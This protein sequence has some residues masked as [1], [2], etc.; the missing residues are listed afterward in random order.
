MKEETAS[1]IASMMET[2][3]QSGTA[4]SGA[5]ESV[6]AAAKTGTAQTGVM[7]DGEEEVICWYTGFFPAQSPRYVVTVMQEGV[8]EN[9][10][11]CA[12]VFAQ[13]ADKTMAFLKEQAGN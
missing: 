1:F 8:T 7:E 3:V 10:G 2:A 11:D 12:A 9:T 5:P 6:T 4:Q 13:I